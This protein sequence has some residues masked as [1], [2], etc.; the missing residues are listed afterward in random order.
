MAFRHLDGLK[1][2]EL[3]LKLGITV[4]KEHCDD[5][6]EVLLEFVERGS[7]AVGPR[8]ARNRT[9]EKA[10]VRIAFDD[11]VEDA[12]V[13]APWAFGQASRYHQPSPALTLLINFELAH[14]A[15]DPPSPKPKV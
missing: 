14:E 8:R 15:R 12:H 10:R 6:P 13:L 1:S 4:I 7:L 5:F 9:D 2:N 11:D 3:R